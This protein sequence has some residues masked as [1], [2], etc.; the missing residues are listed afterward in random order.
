[1]TTKTPEKSNHDSTRKIMFLVVICFFMSGFSGLIY[2]V[3]WT[4]MI[5]RIIGAA[6]FAVSIVLTV[7]MGGLGIGSY[8]A[9][10]TIDRIK[11]P[12][13]LVRIYGLLELLIGGYGLILPLLLILFKPFYVVLYNSLFEYFLL[14][15]FLTFVGCAI[16]F[17]VPVICMG[18]TLP[19]LCRFYVT[20][21]SHLGSHAGRLYGLNTI[22]AA[23][24]SLLCGFWLINIYGTSGT[25]VIAVSINT[26]IG[27]ACLIAARKGTMSAVDIDSKEASEKVLP[28][29]SNRERPAVVRG[30][31][32]I[33]A[34]S[35]FCAM[36]YEVIW[37]KLLGLIVGPTTYSF[38]IVLATFIIGLALGSLLFGWLADRVKR[39]IS[40][41]LGS[42]IVAA[43]LVL[44]MSQLLGNSQLFFAKLIATY[45]DRFTQLHLVKGIVLFGLMLPPTLFLGA[46]FPLVGKIYTSSLSKVGRSIGYAY[47]INTVGAVLGS[48]CAGFVIIPLLGKEDG[49]SLVVGGQI[50]AV[51]V[52]AGFV[53]NQ[54]KRSRI[55]IAVVAVIVLAGLYCC[56]NY[57]AW[58]RRLLA[59][60]KYHRFEEMGVDVKGYG[61]LEALVKGPEILDR[62]DK[63]ELLYYGDGI[64]GFTAV[65]KY[66]HALGDSYLSM[67][68]SGKADA[69]SRGD[70]KTQTLSA[71]FPMLFHKS[72]KNVLVLGLASGITAGEVLYYPVDRLDVLDI[73]REVVKA[74]DF[75][76]P[77]NNNVLNHPKTNMIIQD[78]RAHLELTDQKYD[79][80]ISEPSNPWMAGL[81]TLFT[82]D[83]FASVFDK[84]EE[85]GIFV[86]WV[87]AY[88]MDWET[89]AL[90]GRTFTDVFPSSILV[91]TTPASLEQDYLLVGFRGE[92]RLNPG[93]ARQNIVC[94]QQSKNIN[95]ADHRL[96]FRMII[97][98]NLKDLFGPGLV[99]TDANPVLEF[100]APKLMYFDDPAIAANLESKKWQS[101]ETKNIIRELTSDVKSQIDFASYAVSVYAPFVN[102]VDLSE[103]TDNQKEDYLAM[104]DDY[105]AHNS[106]HYSSYEEDSL[107]SRWRQVQIRIIENSIDTLPDKALSFSYLGDLYRTEN[108]L[109]KAVAAYEKSLQADSD[110]AEVHCN[111]GMILTGM[112]RGYEAIGHFSEALRVRPHYADAHRGLG[113]VLAGTGKLDDAV[114]QFILALQSRPEDPL[115]LHDLALTLAQQGKLSKAVFYFSEALRINPKFANAHCNLGLVLTDLG[116]YQI[117][118]HHF[119]KAL[120]INPDYVEAFNGLEKAV[121]LENIRQKSGER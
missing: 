110:D 9:S 1:M 29:D 84:L 17:C 55:K 35:G 101:E 54:A 79:V 115:T 96:L 13:K 23:F 30:A 20:S 114:A 19:I 73:N 90:I 15:N 33:F 69:S 16:L 26:A 10:R 64:G 7:F 80:I 2:E 100:M 56:L 47:A 48:F 66:T 70:M 37:T 92:G 51:L 24:G 83:F 53:Y 42:Q 102:M 49:L 107:A 78:G 85:D 52:V 14:Y 119:K 106:V 59:E 108:Q 116:D 46:T 68:N 31:L 5:V 105:Y 57:P 4:R 74:S 113:Y 99:N 36:A 39:P 89:F 117:A 82:R 111:L 40:L 28:E 86:Q 6:P 87:H 88:Q 34:V 94:A 22:G 21:L 118:I 62:Y 103:A 81:A 109:N 67:T 25:L 104:M 12:L 44:G 91:S 112:G 98:E 120:E 76:L 97:S 63:S 58:N 3:L 38:T 93:Y 61:W 77:W 95:L 27:L 8:I 18:A 32:V 72:P 11:E 75:F 43:L 71:H 65:L 121:S 41:L 50:L 45:L 60:G